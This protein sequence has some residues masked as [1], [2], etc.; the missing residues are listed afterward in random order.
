MW[1]LGG[2]AR[3]VVQIPGAGH[4]G[5][6]CECRRLSL[7]ADGVETA[8]C[9]DTLRLRDPTQVMAQIEAAGLKVPGYL[10][11]TAGERSTRGTGGDVTA[12]TG[13]RAT[14]QDAPRPRR[15]KPSKPL[16][17]SGDWHTTG[18]CL[19]EALAAWSSRWW[20]AGASVSVGCPRGSAPDD[21]LNRWL[22]PGR[23]DDPGGA[24]LGWARR[25]LA[26]TW[27]A[28]WPCGPDFL[29]ALFVT[30]TTLASGDALL[31]WRVP[32]G[33]SQD[34]LTLPRTNWQRGESGAVSS[35]RG[36]PRYAQR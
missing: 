26:A 5:D 11:A 34:Q 4:G 32:R 13:T 29:G 1:P 14:T 35:P 16:A 8:A 12:E 36:T 31:C 21:V 28:T 25:S 22:A 23:T 2:W 17:V 15:M 18:P 19:D 3:K 20:R 7:C 24:P 6:W 33:R 9:R 30:S 27:H 10:P